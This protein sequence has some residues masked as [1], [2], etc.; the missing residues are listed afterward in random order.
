MFSGCSAA[1]DRTNP[2]SWHQAFRFICPRLVI[3]AL[4][5]RDGGL[6]FLPRRGAVARLE[7]E[8]SELDVRAPMHPSAPLV[9]NR[10]LQLGGRLRA[11]QRGERGAALVVPQGELSEHARTPVVREACESV[12]EDSQSVRRPAGT[13]QRRAVFE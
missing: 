13:K 3:I 5:Q 10:L 1:V 9:G 2:A 7:R 11:A 6:E 12:V 8:F 4:A